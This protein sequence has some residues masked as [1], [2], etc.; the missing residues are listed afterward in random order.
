A[1]E[2]KLKNMPTLS[3]TTAQLYEKYPQPQQLVRQLQRRGDLPADLDL[4]KLQAAGPPQGPPPRPGETMPG[5][6]M[7]APGA[8][9]A[10]NQALNQAGDVDGKRT[11]EYRQ[12]IREY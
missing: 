8:N 3:M 12:K 7:P 6:S 11:A 5:E 1:V 10:P 9:A 2:A 4:Q